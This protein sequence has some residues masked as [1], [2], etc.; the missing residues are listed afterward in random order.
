MNTEADP[1]LPSRP[2]KSSRYY[3]N[4]SGNQKNRICFKPALQNDLPYLANIYMQAYKGM[5]EYGEPS[6]DLAYSYLRELFRICP[7]SFFKAEING[8]I[9]GFIACD[10]HYKDANHNEVMEVHEI[11]VSPAWQGFGLGSKLF[12]FAI[13]LGKRMGRQYMSLCAGEGNVQAIDWYTKKFGFVESG[14]EGRWVHFV[15]K[16]QSSGYV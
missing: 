9:A 3:K 8:T 5:E 10:P 12:N 2:S 11:V 16:L 15:K 7:C 4:R 13:E 14:Q 6:L 1:D